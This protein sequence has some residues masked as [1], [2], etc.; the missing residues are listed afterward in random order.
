MNN[1]FEAIDSFLGISS[2]PI[3]KVIILLALLVY[4]IFTAVLLKQVWVMT[5]ILTGPATPFIKLVSA[6]LFLIS[7]GVFIIILV[8]L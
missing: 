7:A 6:S 3:V 1:I 4:L 2:E 5:K 8:F